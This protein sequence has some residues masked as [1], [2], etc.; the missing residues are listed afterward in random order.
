MPSAMA[1]TT[2]F[3]AAFAMLQ[4][5]DWNRITKLGDRNLRA[6]FFRT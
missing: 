5:N 2:D 3:N 4:R 1:P 6:L